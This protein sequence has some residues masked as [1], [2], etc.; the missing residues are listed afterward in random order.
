MGRVC[1][2]PVNTDPVD[3][4]SNEITATPKLLE[5]LVIKGGGVLNDTEREQTVYQ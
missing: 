1:V 2:V 3:E 4:K 5:L